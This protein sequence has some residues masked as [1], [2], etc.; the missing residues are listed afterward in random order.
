VDASDVMGT[1]S[2]NTS[3][4]ALRVTGFTLMA[5]TIAAGVVVR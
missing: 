3:G 5:E 2:T 1:T 4:A